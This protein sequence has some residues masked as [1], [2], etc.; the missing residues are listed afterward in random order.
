MQWACAAAGR[1]ALCREDHRESPSGNHTGS[2]HPEAVSFCGLEWM[3]SVL[4][5]V[6][7]DVLWLSDHHG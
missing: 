6:Q 7:I 1:G 4:S 2:L 3:L 5:V